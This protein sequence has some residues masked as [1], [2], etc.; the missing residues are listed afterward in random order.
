ML[1]FDLNVILKLGLGSVAKKCLL[2]ED[3]SLVPSTHTGQLISPVTALP[4]G[5]MPSAG[6]YCHSHNAPHPLPQNK[7]KKNHKSFKN[8][9]C[10]ILHF[11]IFF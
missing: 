8:L 1:N 5:Q 7:I 2:L 10:L 6:F 11:F 3:L 4:G 9:N